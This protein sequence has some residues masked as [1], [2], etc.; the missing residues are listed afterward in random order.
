M[1][2]L[3]NYIKRLIWFVIKGEPKTY[4]RVDSVTHGNLLLNKNIVITG[5]SSGIGYAIAK[6]CLVENGNVLCVARNEN[7]LIKAIEMLKAETKS[8]KINYLQWDITDVC[9]HK[10]KCR[11]AVDL[12]G[13]QIDCLVNSAGITSPANIENCTPDLWDDIFNINLRG[14]FFE[15]AEFIKYFIK[16][17]TGGSIVMIA[18]QAGL[19]AQTRPY[20]LSKAALI[21]FSTGL[22][23]ELIQ[24]NVRVN[25]I[26]PGP[27][28]SEMCVIDPDS[29]LRSNNR[30]K[31]IFLPGEV[32][33]T[34][35]FLLSNVSRCITGETIACNEG[36]SIRT[37]AFS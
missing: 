12:L 8:D 22:A 26:A 31:R 5:A 36:N 9:M 1:S 32:A 37:D 19:N 29:N 7:K 35:L 25:A 30:G 17:E 11:Q 18:S 14:L 16:Q 24:H 2:R 4:V 27:T 20:A 13:G 15:T 34:A 23:K 21:H 28:I 33:E 10:E 3:K 6:K